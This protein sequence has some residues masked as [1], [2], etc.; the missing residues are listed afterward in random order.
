MA[1][2]DMALWDAMARLHAVSLVTLLGGVAKDIPV[3]AGI[4]YDGVDGCAAQAERWAKRGDQRASK[5]RS[6]TRRCRKTSL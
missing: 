6:D 5:R 4:G 1:A 2:I 3:Y